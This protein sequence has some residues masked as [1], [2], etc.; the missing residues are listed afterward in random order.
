VVDGKKRPD[1]TFT[2]ADPPVGGLRTWP[3]IK[4]NKPNKSTQTSKIA[5]IPKRLRKLLKTKPPNPRTSTTTTY[6]NILQHARDLG[7]DHIIHAH[8][9]A[10]YRARRDALEIMRGVHVHRC[11]RKFGPSLTCTKCHSPLTNT[12]ILGGCRFTAKFRTQRH[13]STL[14]LLHQLLQDCNGGR[15]PII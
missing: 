15:W 11:Q 3:Q 7:A 4:I 2:D 10:P 13:D 12:H 14:K 8:S 9:E 1:I 5:D 6:N